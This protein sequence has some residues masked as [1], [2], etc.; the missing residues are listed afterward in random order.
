MKVP[1]P[2]S[3]RKF[4]R[5]AT[6]AAGAVSFRRINCPFPAAQS[7]PLPSPLAEFG[8][9]DVTLDS[10]IHEAQLKNT[11]DVLMSLS[12]DSLLRPF[13]QMAEQSAPGEDLGGWYNYDPNYDW[14]KDDAGFA[15]GATFGQWISALA[16]YYVITGSEETSAKVKRLNR[17]Y[18]QTISEKFYDK[19]RFPAYCYD[20]LLL[21]LIDS[22]QFIGDRDALDILER[23]TKAALPHLPGKAIDR[24]LEWRPGKDQSFR[25][26]ESYT[27]PEN[28]FLAYQ[29]GAGNRYREIGIQYLDDK[30][31]FDPLARG[32]NVLAGKHAYSYVN[33]LCSAM[34]AYLTLGSEKH[35]RAAVNGFAMLEAQSFATGGWGPDEM[36]R[37]PDSDDVK[38][39]LTKTHNSFETPCGSY[40]HFKLTRYLLRVTGDSR[41][42]DSME[43]VMYNTV[44]GAKPMQT[45]GRAFYYADYNFDGRKAYSNHRFP[46]CSG[47]LPQVAA[48]YRI[49]TYFRDR[50]GI[51]VNLYVPS[52]LRWVEDGAKI[53]LTQSGEY[54]FEDLISIAIAISQPRAFSVNLRIP[55]WA[56]ES[57]IEVNGKRWAGGVEPGTFFTVSRMWGEGDRIELHLPRKMRLQ[58][59]ESKHPE[60]VALLSGPLVLF[61]IRTDVA[62]PALTRTELLAARQTAK[63]EWQAKARSGSLRLLP[64]MAID[65]ENYS[66]Y[67]NVT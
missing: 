55:E 58:P 52:K 29:R 51:F 22:Y 54:P 43:R 1:A 65:Q 17:L 41:Y 48:D 9:R 63:Q 4:L 19:N 11:H 12:E 59:I 53:S 42:G 21:G 6:G 62:L 31:W 57:R 47:T 56:G 64:Y 8:Y 60:T 23:T 24:E 49:N 16:R 28:L 45:D 5:A 26:D 37:S 7:R 38:G 33:S 32:E 14:H 40:A 66:T 27:N 36:L 50:H 30:T 20:K 18:A 67:L 13:R 15:P 10:Q 25:W 39:S 34:Q 61:P 35:L 46:C 44:L 3:R 2:M